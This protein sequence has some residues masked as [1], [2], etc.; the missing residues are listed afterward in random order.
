MT[1]KSF[2]KQIGCLRCIS[3]YSSI[4][5][6]PGILFINENAEGLV[7]KTPK[8]EI[9]STPLNSRKEVERSNQG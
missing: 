1:G 2:Y 9:T 3:D 8:L 7:P 4:V 5:N 6:L